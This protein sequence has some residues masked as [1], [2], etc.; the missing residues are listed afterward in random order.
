VKDMTTLENM[1]ATKASIELIDQLTSIGI[2]YVNMLVT[3]V[4]RHSFRR[5][6]NIH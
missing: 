6:K 3:K 4:Q 5:T 1:R 2:M